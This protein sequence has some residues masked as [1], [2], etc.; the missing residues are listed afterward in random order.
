[1]SIIKRRLNHLEIQGV[2]QDILDAEPKMRAI[3]V[4]YETI[5]EDKT[6]TTYYSYEGGCNTAIGLCISTL[7]KLKSGD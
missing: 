1:M 2:I 3:V 6:N 4:A 5:N 7:D